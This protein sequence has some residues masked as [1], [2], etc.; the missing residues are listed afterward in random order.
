MLAGEHDRYLLT[1]A[2]IGRKQNEG[3]LKFSVEL[4]GT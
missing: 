2:E 1:F 4:T 3:L